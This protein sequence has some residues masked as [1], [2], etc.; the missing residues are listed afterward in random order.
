MSECCEKC[1]HKWSNRLGPGKDGC[2]NDACP[3]HQTKTPTDH[4]DWQKDDY[5]PPPSTAEGEWEEELGMIFPAAHG[6]LG[7]GNV[8]RFIKELLASE[9]LQAEKE[10]LGKGGSPTFALK[11]G[12]RQFEHGKNAGKKEAFATLHTLESKAPHQDVN[13]NALFV[14]RSKLFLLEEK[15]RG[16]K[17]PANSLQHDLKGGRCDFAANRAL[18]SVLQELRKVLDN[19]K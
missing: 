18:D 13:F 5:T 1:R 16:M 10:A 6:A 19:T 17:V 9:R 8:K 4:K 2:G 14:P 7:F 11:Y 15:I 3:C 12:L